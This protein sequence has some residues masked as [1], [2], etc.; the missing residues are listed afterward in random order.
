MLFNDM[1][2]SIVCSEDCEVVLTHSIII[3]IIL[4][5]IFIFE[6]REGLQ[7]FL[8]LSLS[9]ESACCFSGVEWKLLGA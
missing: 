4:F 5:I 9:S 2:S 1:S 8:S 7:Y 3:I 6:R